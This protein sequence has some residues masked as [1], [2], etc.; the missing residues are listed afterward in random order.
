MSFPVLRMVLF[1]V[2]R[3]VYIPFES[4]EMSWVVSLW[5]MGEEYTCCPRMSVRMSCGVYW[6][7]AENERWSMSDVGIG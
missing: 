4:F 1:S 7:D 3:Q 2:M 5:M 6:L